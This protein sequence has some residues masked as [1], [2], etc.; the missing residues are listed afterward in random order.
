MLKRNYI[1]SQDQI[2]DMLQFLPAPDI[3]C[4]LPLVGPFTHDFGLLWPRLTRNI[5]H[6]KEGKKSSCIHNPAFRYFQKILANT[7]FSRGDNGSANMNELFFI[8]CVFKPS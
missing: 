4:E 8:D 3:P 7:I 6:D 5:A 2:A 1:F